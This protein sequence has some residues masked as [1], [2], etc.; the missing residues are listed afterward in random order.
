MANEY[1][2]LCQV[3]L[4]YFFLMNQNITSPNSPHTS[5][6]SIG[7]VLRNFVK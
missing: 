2:L 5:I 1:I 7:L 3:L 4:Y 6:T